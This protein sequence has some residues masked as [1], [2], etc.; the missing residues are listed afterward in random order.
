MKIVSISCR[1]QENSV[2]FVLA[3]VGGFHVETGRGGPL[4]GRFITGLSP[5]RSLVALA[6]NDESGILFWS[7]NVRR[8]DDDR[9][10]LIS[11]LV[12]GLELPLE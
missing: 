11:A 10:F 3:Q 2:D 1:P 5:T 7:G 8:N 4:T 9:C 6:L 12:T